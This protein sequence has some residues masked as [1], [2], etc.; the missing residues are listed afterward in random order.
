MRKRKNSFPK[1]TTRA[2]GS[3]RRP[4]RKTPRFRTGLFWLTALGFQRLAASRTPNLKL[5]IQKATAP[6]RRNMFV[7]RGA[8]I[9]LGAE[10]P[11]SHRFARRRKG[12]T[13]H[14]REI[15]G[16]GWT[17]CSYFVLMRRL[18]VNRLEVTH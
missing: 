18:K 12:S 13:R 4:Q 16:K 15:A 5:K 1:A 10:I 7:H 3:Q 14:A 17:F 6:R 8:A 2:S 9:S 11:S